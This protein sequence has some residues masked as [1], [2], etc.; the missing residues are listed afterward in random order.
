[1]YVFIHRYI[2]SQII[3]L[4]IKYFYYSNIDILCIYVFYLYENYVIPT[5][6]A[7]TDSPAKRGFWF[8]V[9]VKAL[10]Y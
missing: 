9:V 10:H 3:I 6:R 7:F 4:L 5:C 1:M 8:S 2:Q